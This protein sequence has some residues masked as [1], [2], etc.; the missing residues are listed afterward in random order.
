MMWPDNLMKSI[1]KVCCSSLPVHRIKRQ[2]S[3]QVVVFV[4]CYKSWHTKTP[5]GPPCGAQRAIPRN[6][7]LYNPA[8]DLQPFPFSWLSSCNGCARDN[9][10]IMSWF[11]SS[12]KTTWWFTDPALFSQ[13]GER[14]YSQCVWTERRA[15]K[16]DSLSLCYPVTEFPVWLGQLP[17]SLL[18]WWDTYSDSD[19][20]LSAVIDSDKT[21]PVSASVFSLFLLSFSVICF[22]SA[23]YDIF[24][25]FHPV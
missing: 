16:E 6:T 10:Q 14:E 5:S 22:L 23:A 24:T 19:S 8:T 11:F 15:Q 12:T 3:S 9:G 2:C 18:C 13:T 20:D 4:Y 21:W 25:V 7:K 1:L 17:W